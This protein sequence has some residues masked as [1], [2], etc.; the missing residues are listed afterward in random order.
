MIA[1]MLFNECINFGRSPPDCKCYIDS[2]NE[3]RAS[4]NPHNVK[5]LKLRDIS[6]KFNEYLH[7]SH[8][9]DKSIAQLENFQGNL[10]R[11]NE[12][13]KKWNNYVNSNCFLWIINKIFTLTIK[14]LNLCAVESVIIAKNSKKLLTE[15]AHPIRDKKAMEKLIEKTTGKTLEEILKAKVIFLAN[16]QGTDQTHDKVFAHTVIINYLQ[17]FYPSTTTAI[18]LEGAAFGPGISC[19]Q[20]HQELPDVDIDFISQKKAY[21]TGWENEELLSGHLECIEEIFSLPREIVSSQQK[22]EA[23]ERCKAKFDAYAHAR[24]M[25]MIE[26]AISASK[27][28]GRVF[29]IASS[30]HLTRPEQDYK[31]ENFFTAEECAVV[32]I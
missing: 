9:N 24:N 21:L 23:V 12:K 19:D 26:N 31:I 30:W 6:T 16:D 7:G 2:N 15:D 5:S 17:A 14:E 27:I 11:I 32:T 29:C 10:T 13:I 25:S 1:G 22:S 4:P 8:L 3:M 18:L 20:F 28:V